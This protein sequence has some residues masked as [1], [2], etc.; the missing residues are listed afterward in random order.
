MYIMVSCYDVMHSLQGVLTSE[1][2]SLWLLQGKHSM[3]NGFH[4]QKTKAPLWLAINKF[5]RPQLDYVQDY[6]QYVY[7]VDILLMYYMLYFT[8]L[9]NSN[10]SPV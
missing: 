6:I 5:T 4:E 3:F 9:P 10:V 7:I 8:I 1:P 2:C